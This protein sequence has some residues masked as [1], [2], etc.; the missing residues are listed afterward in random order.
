MHRGQSQALFSGAKWQD[1]RQWPQT[2]T[3]E[4]ASEHQ[5]HFFSTVRMTKHLQRLPR[6]VA[7][8]PSLAIFRNRLNMPLDNLLQVVLHEQRGWTG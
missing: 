3:Q 8:S 2:E 5:K 4:V 1:Q 6:E 7:D